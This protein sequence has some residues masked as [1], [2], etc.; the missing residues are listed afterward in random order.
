M[1]MRRGIRP[2]RTWRA[3]LRC[4]LRRMQNALRQGTLAGRRMDRV[5]AWL[6][7]LGLLLQVGR[8]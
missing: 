2:M 3:V 5:S 6:A 8:Q 1:V 4:V 7:L